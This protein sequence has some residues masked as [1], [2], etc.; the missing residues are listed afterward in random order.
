MF[1]SPN[2]YT[3]YFTAEEKSETFSRSLRAHLVKDT[4][5][6]S[7][8][9][10]KSHVKL[11]TYMKNDNGFELLIDVVF[12]ISPQLDE[13]GPKDQGLVISFRLDEGEILTQFHL[14]VSQ[15]RSEL[16]LFKYQIEKINNLIGK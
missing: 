5:K 15:I 3:K 10:T 11:V 1:L 4:T 9:S 8:K 12:A 13:L 16:F 14:R 2:T 6:S 7:S